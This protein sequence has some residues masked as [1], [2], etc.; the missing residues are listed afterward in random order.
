MKIV[1]E[2]G[3]VNAWLY[4]AD[5]FLRALSLNRVRLHKYY[6]MAQPVPAGNW[7]PGRRGASV[8]VR[9]LLAGDPALTSFPRPARAFPYRF[10]QDAVCLAAFKS[11]IPAGFLWFTVGPY[12]EDEVRCRF[13]PLP[14]GKAA[15]DFDVYVA[16][17]HRSGPI[18]LRLW[19]EANRLLR[20]EGVTWSFSRVSAFNAL[21]VASHSRMGAM[22]V[23]VAT[24]V[25]FGRWQVSAAT[26][27]PFLFFSRNPA[28]VPV[29]RLN[30]ERPSL[31]ED[32]HARTT[33]S[34]H[35]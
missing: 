20:R 17:E 2:L 21:S 28:S 25:I 8:E 4:L 33:T 22:R 10:A 31:P 13:M 14:K 1:H 35:H 26:V 19:D 3:V 34:P 9:R 5:R 12:D 23:G 29:F 32:R 7:L 15:W 18:F 24:F 30:A 11:G 6:F 27:R 16:P